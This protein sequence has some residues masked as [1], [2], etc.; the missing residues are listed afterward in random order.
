MKKEFTLSQKPDTNFVTINGIKY[1]RE[2]PKEES[3]VITKEQ[4][5]EISNWSNSV[6]KE[7]RLNQWFPK[8]FEEEKKELAVGK[9]YWYEGTLFNFQLGNDV[10]GFN[11]DGSWC[12]VSSW[13]WPTRKLYDRE[14]TE[15]EVFEALKNEAV[16]RRYTDRNYRCLVLPEHTHDVVNSYHVN[17]GNLLHG[18]QGYKSNVVFKE[19]KWAEIIPTISLKE[20]E[21]RLNCKIV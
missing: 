14:A 13:V 9:W 1:V 5:K 8:A 20:A 17:E 7:R 10:Y 16:K 11:D 2:E 21:E 19:G 3:F 6:D 4:I 15:Q 18:E 12:D